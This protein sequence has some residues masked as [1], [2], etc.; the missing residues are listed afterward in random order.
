ME[1]DMSGLRRIPQTISTPENMLELVSYG[2][3]LVAV[4]GYLSHDYN[5]DLIT[6]QCTLKELRYQ[7]D[8]AKFVS[9]ISD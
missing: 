5:L 1:E 8:L 2:W 3:N 6:I 7:R 4:Q 9:F